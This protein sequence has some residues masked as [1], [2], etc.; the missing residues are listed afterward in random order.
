[1]WKEILDLHPC[2]VV[3]STLT[4]PPEKLK[5][6]R[7]SYNTNGE[8]TDTKLRFHPAQSCRPHSLPLPQKELENQHQIAT[9]LVKSSAP[10]Y[11]VTLAPSCLPHS[12]PTPENFRKPTL[13][14][15]TNA[16]DIDTKI[17]PHSCTIAIKPSV[18]H[19]KSSE[20]TPNELPLWVH[21]SLNINQIAI[22]ISPKS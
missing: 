9:T 13:N 8:A 6:L 17:R 16:G 15:D 11:D 2:T 19:Q 18:H 3:S 22:S 21:R 14:Y 20:S 1:M 10:K 7:P 5:T 12:L 4:A